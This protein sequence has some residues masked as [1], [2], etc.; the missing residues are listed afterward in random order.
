MVLKAV[1][2]KYCR[3]PVFGR[4]SGMVLKAV[5]YGCV[6]AAMHRD[7]IATG[8]VF[9][10]VRLQADRFSSHQISC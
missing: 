10:S 9:G 2:K 7:E 5:P 8:N 1:Y 3:G 4:S 6:F